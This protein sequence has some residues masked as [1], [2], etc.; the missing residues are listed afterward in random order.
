MST[1]TDFISDSV[2][3]FTLDNNT[4]DN[5]N[6][7]NTHPIFT[8]T[9]VI[10]D[11][12][13]DFPS[14]PLNAVSCPTKGPGKA[15]KPSVK[16]S[17]VTR[18]IILTASERAGRTYENDKE[19]ECLE[20]SKTCKRIASLTNTLI[21]LS[22][23]K[24]GSLCIM[25]TGK[26][27]NVDDA[28]VRIVRE[29]QTQ[30]T[31][32][33]KV[34]KEHFGAIIG[35]K[36]ASLRKLET[37]YF[38]RIAIPKEDDGCIKI[39]G[40]RIHATKCC[41]RILDISRERSKTAS[42]DVEIPRKFYPWIRGPFNENVERW[43]SSGN[44]K[45]NIPPVNVNSETINVNGDRDE[46]MKVIGEIKKIYSEKLEKVRTLSTKVPLSQRRFIVGNRGSGIQEILKSTDCAVEI[47]TDDCDS[48]TVILH[49][50]Q[51]RIVDAL[52]MVYARAASILCK[53]IPCPQ[54]MHRYLIGSK[55]THLQQLFP[56]K[57]ALKIEF[58]DNGTV[59]VEAPQQEFQTSLATLEVEI[60]RIKSEMDHQVI[61]I[62]A[63]FH[64]HIV[65]KGG[66]NITKLRDDYGVSI[67]MPP[68]ETNSLDVIIDGRKD[69][70]KR[71]LEH[72]KELIAKMENEKTRDIIIEHRFHRKI[73]GPKG[74]SINKIRQQYPS[75]NLYFPDANDNDCDIIQ[76]RGNKTE[77]DKVY[78]Y[79]TKLN[80][81]FIESSYQETA[82]IFKEFLKRII[83]KG[84][85]T[86][87]KIRDETNT[88]IDLPLDSSPTGKVVVT[89]KKENVQKAI[90]MLTKIQEEL[91][92]IVTLDVPIP[93]KAQRR[94]L[95]NGRRLLTD[96]ENECG[97][98][99]FNI[100]EKT[101][102]IVIRGPK[103][104]V[105]N[106]EK[107]VKSLLKT[108]NEQTEEVTI[109]ADASYHK[110]LIGKQGNNLQA[111]REKYPTVRVL[112]P[113]EK[114]ENANTINLIGKNDE[115][116][117]VK[118]ILEARIEELKQTV[119]LHIN[120]PLEYQ[121]HFLIK[122]S[123]VLK[124]IQSQNGNVQIFFPRINSNSTLVT[125]KGS[126]VCAE[127]AKN[128]ILEIVDDL[129]A[130]VT[131]EVI[132]PNKYLRSI[133]GSYKSAYNE[134]PKEYNV[135]IKLP[136]RRLAEEYN[137]SGVCLGDIITITGRAEKCEQ[138]KSA[139]LELVPV[140][141]EIVVS[142]EFHSALI[143]RGGKD[144]RNLQQL[145]SVNVQIPNESDNSDIIKVVGL[146]EKVKECIADIESR[147]E[148]LQKIA[149]DNMLKSF[150]LTV[151]IPA[152]YHQ[153]LIGRKGVVVAG[154]RSKYDVQI[155]F[156][157]D[158]DNCDDIIIQGYEKNCNEC[159]EDMLDQ[160]AQWE[161][162]I[163]MT[164]K[165]D[166][167]Y[168]P[169][170]IGTGGRNLRKLN[171]DFG[172]D[173][174][175]PPKNAEDPSLVVIA[176]HTE[177]DILN[178]IEQL[179]IEEEDYIDLLIERGQYTIERDST[180]AQI[181]VKRSVEITNAPWQVNSHEQFP[182]IG[183]GVPTVTLPVNSVW[184]SRLHR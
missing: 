151:S 53:E 118:K 179:K 161:A 76:I 120:V 11:Y 56:D 140:T 88:Q 16:C 114:A 84:G 127:S 135:V 122:G 57:V 72:I 172:V 75:I 152:E 153:K 71:C 62:P 5:G 115:V 119:E 21:E 38:C 45:V 133:L 13:T 3:A 138:A 128:R 39:T 68:E 183:S 97:N 80:K 25:V 83:G 129:K 22:E 54:W 92:N 66:S 131:I 177:D 34:P 4:D 78:T 41:D 124:E 101:N 42:E 180:P 106:A 27:P 159:K 103:I 98:V 94:F 93:P 73:I 125:I 154:L 176:G 44:V 121:R 184:S 141:I 169:R 60:D 136:D 90:E 59:Y 28:H 33:I 89:G 173:I 143:G 30:I 144:I 116:A 67:V 85:V 63:E 162:M 145:Y 123:E 117:A 99:F 15:L 163:T 170:M 20:E 87:N 175:L 65:G 52:S 146:R 50:D 55:G 64:R 26:G 2:T 91:A 155:T 69:G 181:Q 24:D 82:P 156:P 37:D 112:F 167:R 178:C 113:E 81:E 142:R 149:T 158:E 165:L 40:P 19:M 43:T 47:P 174:R 9:K 150:K 31:L 171:E 137:N 96:I 58:N 110:F 107:L 17:T 14:L 168:H 49:G 51:E 70:V 23:A 74:E 100:K 134:I 6:Q 109:A 111:L 132:V 139:L 104:P 8:E 95:F 147:V 10:M 126:E 79:L 12:T 108:L 148:E 35:A 105:E 182:S 160:V 7:E 86:I 32:S 77:V 18:R 46:V 36:G 61:S 1:M 29:L 157:K 164:V 48:G 130:Q 166:P 102:K